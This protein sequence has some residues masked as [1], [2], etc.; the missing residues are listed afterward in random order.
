MIFSL[1]VEE[2]E[3]LCFGVKREGS[4]ISEVERKV[5]VFVLGNDW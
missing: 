3:E 4:K 2:R 1:Y 5:G